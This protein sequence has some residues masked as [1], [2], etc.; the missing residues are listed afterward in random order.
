MYPPSCTLVYELL[1]EDPIGP[2]RG[3]PPPTVLIS[4]LNFIGTD[5]QDA[6]FQAGPREPRGRFR[7][8]TH[9]RVSGIRHIA[10]TNTK[11]HIFYQLE[12]TLGSA[13]VTGRETSTHKL[14]HPMK[15]TQRFSRL[16][17]STISF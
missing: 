12:K 11:H 17:A 14:H 7:A 5:M 1:A 3:R 2:H 4:S 8:T 13:D 16:V 10:I 15:A 9:T 6:T